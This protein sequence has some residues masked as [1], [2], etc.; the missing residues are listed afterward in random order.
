[1]P[2][3]GTVRY[4]IAVS[5]GFGI[6]GFLANLFTFTLVFRDYKVAMVWGL[7]FPLIIALSWGWKF[8]L[9][10]ALAGGA[11]SLWLLW[12]PTNGYVA[13]L[14]VPTFT[15]WIV[16]HG[17]F[18]LKRE[19][20]D[21][22]WWMNMYVIEMPFRLLTT[23]N[24]LFPSRWL[25]TSNPPSWGWTDALTTAPL[26]FSIFVAIKQ[27]VEAYVLL[28]AADVLLHLRSV[29]R[30]MK[31]D[32]DVDQ[33]DTGY[34]ISLFLLIGCLFWV[35][36]SLFSSLFT[37]GVE[38]SA[39]FVLDVPRAHLFTRITFLVA[40]LGVGL[41]TARI[42]RS[43]RLAA[44]QLSEAKEEAEDRETFF[45]ALVRAIPDPV[46]L[47]D[48][49]G[50]YLLCNSEV[51]RLL[52]ATEREI[53]GKTDF[54]LI[55]P[56]VAEEFRQH[57]LAA[58]DLPPDEKFRVTHSNFVASDGNKQVRETVKT[59]MR[60]TRG[61]LIGVLG[62][63]RDVTDRVALEAQLAQVQRLDSMG[64][65]AGGIAHDLNNM[66]TVILFSSEMAL[67]QLAEGDNLAE[68]G[69]LAEGIRS[70]KTAAERSSLLT[71][72]LLAFAR[73]QPIVPR[74]LNLNT[75]I[76]D[77]LTMMTRLLGENI[78]VTTRLADDLWPVTADAAQLEQ[79]LTN[80]FVNARDAIGGIGE[81]TIE[82]ANAPGSHNDSTG[83]EG[84][85]VK[86]TVTDTGCG[87][88]AETQTRIFEPF[89]STKE[90]GV[91]SGLGLAT[92]WGIVAQNKGLVEVVSEPGEGSSF[93]VFLPRS[94]DKPARTP[95]G[96]TIRR[97]SALANPVGTESILIVEDQTNVLTV[98]TAMLERLGY[99]VVGFTNPKE[100]LE[101]L[102]QLE[103]IDL[104][105][106]DVVLPEMNGREVAEAVA[107]F[108]PNIRCLFMSGYTADVLAPHGVLDD[109]VNLIDKPFTIGTLSQKV[110]EVLD[111]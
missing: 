66:L 108:N 72:Q 56:E 4:K 68:G 83:A 14:F 92:V 1:M 37:P 106:T 73:K 70:I 42:M 44:A 8:G 36:D 30:F 99:E 28:L 49:H 46:W 38:F 47:K 78:V 15:L 23:L 100:A 104:L 81:I 35:S 32:P 50:T 25:V 20:E 54:D 31:L 107:A 64:R 95:E 105:L 98:A 7:I 63:S 16:W 97:S 89:F 60:G 40:F 22:K 45:R 86:L 65:L 13:F 27:I 74:T 111:T 18:A 94:A 19:S 11:Q 41:A 76:T 3:R 96:Q 59:A 52:G 21:A 109:G 101:A 93:T 55:N 17:Y 84:D 79:V 110:R 75:V 9:L 57:D 71:G 102:P 24:L 69:S 62:V 34:I 80:L 87:M 82:T 85:F 33:Q 88:D 91:G 2:Q 29:R 48:V 61:E 5:V 6:A 26:E 77:S 10:S 39:S 12:G 53:V 58:I 103:A 51:E 90:S 67:E 43:Q